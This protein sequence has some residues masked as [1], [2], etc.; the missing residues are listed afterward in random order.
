LRF[1][2]A[3]PDDRIDQAMTF[4]PEAIDRGDRVRRYLELNPQYVLEQ[5]YLIG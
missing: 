1:S 2:C 3:E 5:S 4:L